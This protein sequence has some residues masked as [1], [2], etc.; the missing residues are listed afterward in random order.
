LEVKF[1]SLQ[2]LTASLNVLE[3]T[4]FAAMPFINQVGCLLVVLK[5]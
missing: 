5:D 1:T 2:K 3:P 4:T